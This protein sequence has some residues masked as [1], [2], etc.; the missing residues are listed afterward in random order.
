MDMT[1]RNPKDTFGQNR[2]VSMPVED[3]EFSQF[4][5]NDSCLGNHGLPQKMML[6]E[7][8]EYESSEDFTPHIITRMPDLTG[9][10]HDTAPQGISLYR[11]KHGRGMI[12]LEVL[13]MLRK[14][15]LRNWCGI[16]VIMTVVG[17]VGWSFFKGNESQLVAQ[18]STS[19][20]SNLETQQQDN[21]PHMEPLRPSGGFSEFQFDGLNHGMAARTTGDQVT[22]S[23]GATASPA[24]QNQ[25]FGTQSIVPVDTTVPGM[26]QYPYPSGATGTA[27]ATSDTRSRDLPPWEHQPQGTTSVAM[28]NNSYLSYSNTNT[29]RTVNTPQTAP[30]NTYS[31]GASS[32]NTWGQNGQSHP[33]SQPQGFSGMAT[34]Y[35]SSNIQGTTGMTAGTSQF[36]G[37][38]PSNTGTMPYPPQQNQQYYGSASHQI[39]DGF[40]AMAQQVSYQQTPTN[41]NRTVAANTNN[42]SPYS[43]I[44][45]QGQWSSQNTGTGYAQQ[46]ANSGVQNPSGNNH[47]SQQ[48][49]PQSYPGTGSQYGAQG[50]T[51]PVFQS[52]MS[53]VPVMASEYSYRGTPTTGTTMPGSINPYPGYQPLPS[54][55]TNIS[56]TQDIYR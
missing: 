21:T 49:Q 29:D 52:G 11:P 39:A 7:K 55:N 20:N 2:M 44:Q 18:K 40:G 28:A 32:Q 15:P 25:Y 31:Q 1:E 9:Y 33:Q 5:K 22:F 37:A 35:G 42:L 27:M 38:T 46:N 8:L 53:N 13:K 16:L 17:I 19:A 56:Q 12:H 43:Q 23:S 10:G 45:G 41:D 36:T 26:S 51:Q 3:Q 47:Y 50:N 6:N 48:N 34:E 24:Q 14:Q 30:L 54:H 4:E